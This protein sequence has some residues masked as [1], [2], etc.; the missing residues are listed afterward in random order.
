MDASLDEVVGH[1]LENVFEVAKPIWLN[2]KERAEESPFF[3]HIKPGTVLTVHA[4]IITDD[5]LLVRVRFPWGSFSHDAMKC[6]GCPKIEP[7][8]CVLEDDCENTTAE[9]PLDL[10]VTHCELWE[11]DIQISP[12]VPLQ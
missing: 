6:A 9:F 4:V 11:P 7:E 8:K 12:L 10:L 2:E 3:Q 5:D 1:V